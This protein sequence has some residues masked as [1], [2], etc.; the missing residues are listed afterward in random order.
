M[1]E[2]G[3]SW[4]LT[5]CVTVGSHLTLLGFILPLQHGKVELVIICCHG[6]GQ[7]SV[8]YSARH[9]Q[10]LVSGSSYCGFRSRGGAST[11]VSGTPGP[12][13]SLTS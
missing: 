3:S 11:L 8:Q 1:F 9:S 12:S 2:G 7:R 10:M 6:D 13:G 4:P 5:A